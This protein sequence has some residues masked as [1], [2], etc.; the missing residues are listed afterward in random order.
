MFRFRM[1]DEQLWFI[2]IRGGVKL[3]SVYWDW[4]SYLECVGGRLSCQ[5][6]KTDDLWKRSSLRS[7][8][9]A[10]TAMI[11]CYCL[12]YLLR[13]KS[14]DW[15]CNTYLS[16]NVFPLLSIATSMLKAVRICWIRSRFLTRSHVLWMTETISDNRNKASMPVLQTLI[17]LYFSLTHHR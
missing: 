9:D 5:L 8:L 1:L 16:G 10:V 13:W 4:L 14:F 17:M 2:I 15:M 6:N 11:F 12:Y 3:S 7:L